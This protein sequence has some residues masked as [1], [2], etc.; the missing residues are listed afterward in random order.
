MALPLF[1]NL[2]ALLWMLI[3][4][5]VSV[6]A[7]YLVLFPIFF[8]LCRLNGSVSIR[9]AWSVGIVMWL[10]YLTLISAKHSQYLVFWR[11]DISLL[12]DFLV[13]AILASLAVVLMWVTMPRSSNVGG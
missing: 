13:L 10:V 1:S 11:G 4:F 9:L 8:Y 5:V 2:D 6:A 12:M 7:I 3:W